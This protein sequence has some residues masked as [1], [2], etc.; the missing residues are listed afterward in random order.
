MTD[1]TIGLYNYRLSSTILFCILY[2]YMLAK[3]GSYLKQQNIQGPVQ[4]ISPSG[5]KF[6]IMP[7]KEYTI[8][9][10]INVDSLP[11]DNASAIISNIADDHIDEDLVSSEDQA[12]NNTT[13]NENEHMQ[14]RNTT[15]PN[16]HTRQG[17][18]GKASALAQLQLEE[19]INID[20]L[21]L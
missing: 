13:V 4:F 15:M 11:G 9:T 14:A 21:P 3:V 7:A 19:E 5:E 10:G 6:V 12:P 17:E 20:D 16:H 18:E 2:Y 8:L 1:F